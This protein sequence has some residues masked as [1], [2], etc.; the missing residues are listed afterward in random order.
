MEKHDEELRAAVQAF[1][2]AEGI[3]FEEAVKVAINTL[4]DECQRR[5]EWREAGPASCNV[6]CGHMNSGSALEV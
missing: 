4:I 3:S 6:G 5:R 1:C 2:D